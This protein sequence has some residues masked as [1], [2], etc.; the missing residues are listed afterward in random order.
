MTHLDT[1]MDVPDQ[2]EGADVHGHVKRI[3]TK[4]GSEPNDN[5]HAI[6]TYRHPRSRCGQPT[7]PQCGDSS[8]AGL[9][10]AT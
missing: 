7:N 3:V 8:N 9:S 4:D 5:H 6:A 1:S 2:A 10:A